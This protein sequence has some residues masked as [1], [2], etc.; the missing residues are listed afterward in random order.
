MP[1]RF[2]GGIVHSVYGLIYSTSKPIRLQE[3]SLQY[4]NM[5]YITDVFTVC[6]LKAIHKEHLN[7]D[8]TTY[9]TKAMKESGSVLNWPPEWR[10]SLVDKH[11]TG[12][13]GDKTSLVLIPV[14]A[15][16]NL[17]VDV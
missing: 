4:Y 17:K 8:E 6:M 13:V 3:I 15:A 11:S 9:L 10:G 16:C 7:D 2:K 1:E 5:I 14:L 12:G